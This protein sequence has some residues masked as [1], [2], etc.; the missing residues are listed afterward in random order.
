MHKRKSKSFYC[1][2]KFAVFEDYEY[3][4]SSVENGKFVALGE[5]KYTYNPLENADII[6]KVANLKLEI[7]DMITF[8][9][10][11]GFFGRIVE[12]EV[13]HRVQYWNSIPHTRAFKEEN[14]I[15][16]ITSISGIKSAVQ[17]ASIS[18]REKAINQENKKIINNQLKNM[19]DIAKKIDKPDYIYLYEDAIS[20]DMQIRTKEYISRLIRG[21]SAFLQSLQVIDNE[22]VEAISFPTLLDV[23]HYQIAN[24]LIE[25]VEFRRCK[26]CQE[27]FLAQHGRQN[28]CAPLPNRK[29]STCEN[30]YRQRQKRKLNKN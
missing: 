5:I 12:N 25:G 23:A 3:V 10:E 2:S 8:F 22:F 30:T 15:A 17:E 24:A 19:V 28:F 27:W 11:Y 21:N 6:S 26:Y 9:K 13:F 16:A 29:R 4:G 14:H 20:T 1:L 7:E 18:Q